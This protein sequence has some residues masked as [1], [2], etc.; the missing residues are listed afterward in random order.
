VN[1]VDEIRCKE[2]VNG[3]AVVMCERLDRGAHIATRRRSGE[4][5][6]GAIRYLSPKKNPMS[7]MVN[8]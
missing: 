3:E 7:H 2:A 8:P 4:K 6:C 5:I 1:L